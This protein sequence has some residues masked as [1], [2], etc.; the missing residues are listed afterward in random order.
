MVEWEVNNAQKNIFNSDYSIKVN[1]HLR[2]SAWKEEHSK[3]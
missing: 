2:K 3:N 1:M